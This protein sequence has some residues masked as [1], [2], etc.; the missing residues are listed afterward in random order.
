M[1]VIQAVTVS[2][3]IMN[4]PGTDSLP[5]AETSLLLTAPSAGQELNEFWENGI[6]SSI[7]LS[8]VYKF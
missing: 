1:F 8:K 2:R 6:R 4:N 5:L 7:S 3:L